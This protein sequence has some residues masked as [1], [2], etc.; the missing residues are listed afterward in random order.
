MNPIMSSG[1]GSNWRI[2]CFAGRPLSNLGTTTYMLEASLRIELKIKG[3][4]PFEIPFLQLAKYFYK[5][6]N[7]ELF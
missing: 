3:Y 4:E 5:T 7:P 2:F 6:K 1:P